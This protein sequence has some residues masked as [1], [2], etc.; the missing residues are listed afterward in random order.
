MMMK[1]LFWP[2]AMVLFLLPNA[3]SFAAFHTP[4]CRFC[5]LEIR[6]DGVCLVLAVG[7]QGQ[8]KERFEKLVSWSQLGT[9]CNRCD[10]DDEN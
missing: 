1:S 6:G 4:C 2:W 9:A 5:F 7:L 10:R 8:R 3:S